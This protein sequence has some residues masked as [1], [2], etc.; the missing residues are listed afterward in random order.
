MI[1]KL[2]AKP[3]VLPVTALPF[4]CEKDCLSHLGQQLAPFGS[5]CNTDIDSLVSK[6]G[7]SPEWDLLQMVC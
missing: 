4:C 5:I 6:V 7:A 2:P 3:Q 1:A